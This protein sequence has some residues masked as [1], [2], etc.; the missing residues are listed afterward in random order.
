ML[1]R[2]QVFVFIIITVSSNYHSKSSVLCSCNISL[3]H[4]LSHVSSLLLQSA[5][6]LSAEAN[7]GEKLY[8]QR[9]WSNY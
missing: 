4:L 6:V 2:K 7:E 5:E 1:T 9:S 3:N 8:G